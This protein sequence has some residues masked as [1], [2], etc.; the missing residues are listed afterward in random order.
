[1]HLMAIVCSYVYLN[2]C[3]PDLPNVGHQLVS[4]DYYVYLLE[5]VSALIL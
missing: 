5:F 1:M 4:V 3:P 2:H